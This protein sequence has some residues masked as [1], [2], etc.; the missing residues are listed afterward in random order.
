MPLVPPALNQCLKPPCA[1]AASQWSTDRPIFKFYCIQFGA[2]SQTLAESNLIPSSLFNHRCQSAFEWFFVWLLNTQSWLFKVTRYKQ[3]YDPLPW[4]WPLFWHVLH[5]MLFHQIE[6]LDF[7]W[8]QNHSTSF[9]QMCFRFCV[10]EQWL[11]KHTKTHAQIFFKNWFLMFLITMLERWLL[12]ECNV[13]R[14]HGN[15][16]EHIRSH[17]MDSSTAIYLFGTSSYY[18]CSLLVLVALLGDARPVA[19][20]IKA[21]TIVSY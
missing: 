17:I 13:L 2:H 19:Y 20:I 4:Q 16:F 18:F 11:V 15:H 6:L 3:R 7:R 12:T 9:N 5:E 21:I 8:K 10:R 1:Q 14:R